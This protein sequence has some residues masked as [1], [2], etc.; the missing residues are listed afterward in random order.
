MSIKEGELGMELLSDKDIFSDVRSY[1]ETVKQE[2]H[3]SGSALVIIKDD[4]FIYE[5]YSGTHHFGIGAKNV[6]A[7]SRFNVYSVRV[8]YVG[9][10]VAI[11]IHDGLLSLDDRVRDHLN[12]YDVDILGD[13][14]IK[15]LLTRC[16]GLKFERN[17]VSRVFDLETNIEGKKPDLLAKIVYNA[18]GKTV[19]EILTN[20]VFKP[21][22]LTNTSWVTAGSDNLV[23]DFDVSTG[24]STL[25]MG[26]NIG[27]ERNLY[28]SAR[29]LALWGN[30]HLNKGRHEDE[31]ILHRNIFD[32]ATS[33]QSPNRLPK[34]L[35]KFGFLWWIKDRDVT[36]KYNE[37]GS[38]LPDG[39]YQILGAS[40]CSCTVI[41]QFNMVAVR[42]Y[43]SIHAYEE[44][45]FDYIKDIQKFGNLIV[46]SANKLQ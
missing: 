32:L 17:T 7:T 24:F 25:R 13:T 42:M 20:K 40:G 33:I 23:C 45:G 31:Q 6:N 29:E 43:N 11:A 3:A 46:Q 27:D 34:Q 10:A 15:H 28:V 5:G 2:M 44:L 26:S 37:L 41:P 21:L 16:T 38:D 39:T 14:T 1:V 22:N 18:T 8:T 30:L 12:E 9:L 19:N 35:P 4:K 36:F